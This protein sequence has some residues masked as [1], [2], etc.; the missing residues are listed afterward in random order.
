M[1]LLS[2]AMSLHH[3]AIMT[4][5]FLSCLLC[6]LCMLAIPIFPFLKFIPTSYFIFNDLS[7]LD[8][9]N[10]SCSVDVLLHIITK[11]ANIRALGLVSLSLFS[12]LC[13]HGCVNVLLRMYTQVAVLTVVHTLMLL[14]VASHRCIWACMVDTCSW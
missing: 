7:I 9:R 12:H 14:E 3:L 2:G 6:F 10:S 11:R 5:P 1:Y 13:L 4:K 8:C